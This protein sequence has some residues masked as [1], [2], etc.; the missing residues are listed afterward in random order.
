MSAVRIA[1]AVVAHPSRE[2]MV[3]DLLA[4]MADL[5][6][7]RSR[8]DYPEPGTIW[9][10]DVSW[11]REQLGSWNNSRRAWLAGLSHEWATHVCVLEDDALPC[12]GFAHAAA[13]A[14]A[15]RPEDVVSFFARK[16]IIL[17]ARKKKLNWVRMADMHTGV[18]MAAPVDLVRH[19]LEW[20]QRYV[21]PECPYSDQRM[22]MYLLKHLGACAWFTV[23]SLVDHRGDESL[24]EGC[25]HPTVAGR[26]ATLFADAPEY[27][28]DVGSIR[29]TDDESLFFQNNTL[30][31]YKK[32]LVTNH[33]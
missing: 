1:F 8:P 2:T 11:D 6:G 33:G 19:W 18:C 28:G 25:P 27:G 4:R 20:E 13:S 14:L 22:G 30:E 10:P 29:W 24:M 7:A 12:S 15:A 31:R 21:S 16:P 17:T 32:W 9:R 26:R 5:R 3:R 23:P